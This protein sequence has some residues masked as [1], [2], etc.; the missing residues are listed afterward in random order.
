MLFLIFLQSGQSYS[1]GGVEKKMWFPPDFGE[2]T[3]D[4]RSGL[5]LDPDH[6]FTKETMLSK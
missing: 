3:L 2:Q 4:K 5:F 6:V 1:I